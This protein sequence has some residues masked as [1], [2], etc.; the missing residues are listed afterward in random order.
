MNI[1]ELKAMDLRT[2]PTEEINTLLDETLSGIARIAELVSGFGR[3]AL[4]SPVKPPL[5]V[6]T[7]AIAR[8]IAARHAASFRADPRTHI[9]AFVDPQTVEAGIDALLVFLGKQRKE[10]S[11]P[12]VV[13]VTTIGDRPVITV[14]DDSLMLSDTERLRLFDPRVDVDTRDGRTMRLDL[15]LALAYQA[16]R[17][18]GV[19]VT[20]TGNDERG[21]RIDLL[22]PIVPDR[23]AAARTL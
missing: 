23:L 13:E 11:T 21:V 3:L 22:L 9:A 12:V 4:P 14:S 10:S 7:V 16:L 17:A 1:G 20:V 19:D 2:A 5:R 15:E 18:N 8:P 6:E